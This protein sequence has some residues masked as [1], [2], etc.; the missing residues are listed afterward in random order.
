MYAGL[1]SLH[2]IVRSDGSSFAM[3]QVTLH[4]TID[5][6][7]VQAQDQRMLDVQDATERLD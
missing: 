3:S 4:I 1:G 7:T 5:D 6:D 2:D